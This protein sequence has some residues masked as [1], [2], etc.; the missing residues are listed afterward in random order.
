MNITGL[1]R[2]VLGDLQPSDTKVLELKVGQVVKG[3][4]LQLLA[5]QDALL[6]IGGVQVRARLETPLKQGE[7]TLLQV[8]PE[9]ANGQTVL[10]P[11]ASSD[12]PISE[13]S[14]SDL[15]MDFGVKDEPANRQ[16]LQQ[17]QREGVPLNKETVREF[18]GLQTSRP[19]G[20]SQEDWTQS[21]GLAF[22]RGLPVTPETVLPLHKAISGPPMHEVL[23]QLQSETSGFL[24]ENDGLQA[25]VKQPLQQM[26]AL[27]DDVL[28]ASE[29]SAAGEQAKTGAQ[30]D[31][32]SPE[33]RTFSPVQS[34]GT[35]AVRI[36]QAPDSN[37]S[38]FGE[39]STI[40]N[41]GGMETEPEPKAQPLPTQ[42]QVPSARL[43][44]QKAAAANRS[45]PEQ[46]QT[47]TDHP[48]AA[49][50]SKNDFHSRVEPSRD[51]N[52][53][54]EETHADH[55]IGRML[56]A[57]GVEHEHQLAKLLD[58]PD[59]AMRRFQ[60]ELTAAQ[61]DGSPG[62]TD[63]AS[64]PAAD[65]LKSLLLQLSQSDE[66]SSALKD[67]M[68]QAI[69]QIT[70]QQLLLSPD[71]S[72]PF[73]H[74]TLFIPFRNSD[75]QQTAAVH[76]QSRR[77]GRGQLDASNCRLLFDLHMRRMGNTLLDVQVANR[78]VSLNVHND[79]PA[80]PALLD[81]HKDEISTS[82]ESVGYHLLSLKF[83]PYPAPAD[84]KDAAAEEASNPADASRASLKS[85]YQSKPYKGVDL[86]V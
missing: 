60:G 11:L 76:I 41:I 64:K 72:T 26:L 74:I 83:S 6:N 28:E 51:G 38:F 65:T 40:R 36:E 33:R 15:L 29:R 43:T 4:V 57:L 75:G 62:L 46:A 34:I 69:Q 12:V 30:F 20:V 39:S 22:K 80:V 47:I 2:S 42:E 13:R 56:K 79:H 50:V 37:T 86:R 66:V 16:L 49:P 58:N 5:E 14:L 63:P 18:V 31:Q 9:S 59:P 52:E 70:G 84:F 8:Q 3:L 82:L 48:R 25:A 67:T 78:I 53:S 45:D 21:A 24:K 7:V 1:L 23:R 19:T 68:Q 73:A 44:E 77:G 54:M 81:A 71:R 17:M 27:I 85:L 10:K 35:A 32:A 55:W 61:T